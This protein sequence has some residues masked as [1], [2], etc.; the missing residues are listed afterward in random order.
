[1]QTEAVQGCQT[2]NS[3]VCYAIETSCSPPSQYLPPNGMCAL[4]LLLLKNTRLVLVI[5]L[6]SIFNRPPTFLCPSSSFPPFSLSS[7][8]LWS[9]FHFHS[10]I[11]LLSI[12]PSPVPP[13]VPLTHYH[14][15]S[16]TI[17]RPAAIKNLERKLHKRHCL[18]L[19][20]RQ[21]YWEIR[22][23][24]Q[25]RISF[26]SKNVLKNKIKLKAKCFEKSISPAGP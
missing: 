20:W 3:F 19:L 2:H 11:H 13:H 9:D 5:P 6:F 12:T 15:C 1:M 18:C 14:I 17:S 4:L 25:T 8:S 10:L 22:H 7:P 16:I 21:K 23:D 24:E 26:L